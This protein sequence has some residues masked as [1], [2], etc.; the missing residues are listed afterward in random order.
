MYQVG[1]GN[2]R[3]FNIDHSIEGTSDG[4]P[5]PLKLRKCNLT[6]HDITWSE[7]LAAKNMLRFEYGIDVGYSS[8][9]N[10]VVAQR[11]KGSKILA[12]FADRG[13]RY[14]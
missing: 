2:D 11:V 7:V 4:V 9:A 6:V 14:E 1:Y 10:F 12:I 5:L 13:D 3:R 8:A